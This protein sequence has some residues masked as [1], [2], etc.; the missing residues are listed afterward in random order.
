MTKQIA[1]NK[2]LDKCP[3]CKEERIGIQEGRVYFNCGSF[4]QYSRES[5]IKA[6]QSI[7]CQKNIQLHG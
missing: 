2:S 1:I 4:I 6:R 7:E 3:F 5:K